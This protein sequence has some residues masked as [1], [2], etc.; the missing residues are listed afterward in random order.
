M[1]CNSIRDRC[2][3]IIYLFGTVD[4]IAP[5]D[6]RTRVMATKKYNNIFILMTTF[7]R[8]LWILCAYDIIRAT[9]YRVVDLYNFFFIIAW[10]RN[11]FPSFNPFEYNNVFSLFSSS[12][13]T[14]PNIIIWQNHSIIVSSVVIIEGGKLKYLFYIRTRVT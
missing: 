12:S 4:F 9:I 2:F 10:Y 6:S 8:T 14:S 5:D 13:S 1:W 3:I 11:R 7:F